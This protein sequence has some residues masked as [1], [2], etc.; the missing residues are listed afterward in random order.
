MCTCPVR[1]H[2][3]VGPQDPLE[4]WWAPSLVPPLLPPPDVGV[5]QGPA[6]KPLLST[7]TPWAASAR[8]PLKHQLPHTRDLTRRPVQSPVPLTHRRAD[9]IPWVAPP[10]PCT[11]GPATATRRQPEAVLLR[12]R[13]T[14]YPDFGGVVATWSQEPLGKAG[15]SQR[16]K[17][18]K[19]GGAHPCLFGG[20]VKAGGPPAQQG[21]PG[22]ATG[23]RASIQSYNLRALSPAPREPAGPQQP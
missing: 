6:P 12:S 14:E 17:Q 20:R 23:P 4:A 16:P 18:E 7:P 11:P 13:V 21:A 8:P 5:S 3:R 9:G 19:D 10:A 15:R 22:G 2:H 1:I